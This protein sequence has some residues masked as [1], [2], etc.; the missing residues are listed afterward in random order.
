MNPAIIEEILP[1]LVE[2]QKELME[3]KDE[4]VETVEELKEAVE[5]L[6]ETKNVEE[7]TKT[8]VRVVEDQELQKTFQ[9]CLPFLSRFWEK[10]KPE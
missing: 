5:E 10:K 1:S 4:I 6:I 9:C 3:K 8:V 2:T 7:F